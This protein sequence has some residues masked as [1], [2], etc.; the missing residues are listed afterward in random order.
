[1]LAAL[2]EINPHKATGYDMLPPRV[3]KM[4]AE[5]LATPLTTIFNL[6]IEENQWPS[7]WKSGE[8][9]PIYKKEDPLTK[10]ITDQ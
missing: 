4:A 3:L 1:M 6:A 10:S 9:I 7:A 2:R 5:Q 8:W